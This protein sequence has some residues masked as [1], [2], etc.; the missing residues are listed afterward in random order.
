MPSFPLSIIVLAAGKGKRMRTGLP[1]VLHV[2]AGA[3]LLERVV[4]TAEA[5]QPNNIYVVAGNGA[6]RVQKEMSHLNVEWVQQKEQLGTGHAVQQVLPH[7]QKNHQVLILYGDVPL[8]SIQT[9]QALLEKTPKNA[10]GLVV[11]ELDDPKGFGRIIR[12]DVGNIVAIVEQKDATDEQLKIK[13]INTGII[14]VSAEHLYEWLPK[15]ENNNQQKEYYLTDIIAMAVR[16]GCSV[17]G[18]FADCQEEVR[19]VNNLSELSMLE[20]FYHRQKAYELMAQGVTI[21]DPNR[22]DMRGKLH[23]APD[24]I[25]DINVIFEGE[26]SI[27]ANTT[28]GPNCVLK[29]VKIGQNVKIEANSVI[30]GAIIEDQAVI[31]P[32]A[33]IRPGTHVEKKAKVGNFVEL[34]N[35]RLG[36][37]SKIPHLS[38][39][40]D[41]IVGKHVNIGAGTITVNYDGVNKHQ[42]I[43][44][45]TAFIGCD[46]QLIAP[47][48]VGEGAYIAAG[49]TITQDAPPRQLTIA[50]AK[51]CSIPDWKPKQKT[52]SLLLKS[53]EH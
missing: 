22:F 33:R 7:L 16:D 3:T 4:H 50:R 53:D 47:V 36:E 28:I 17:G 9:L 21:M 14:T 23:V 20:R 52:D 10:L 13:E 31:G 18:V 26:V 45:D 24:V 37:Q 46:S 41:A 35:V 15:L 34:K 44:E 5:L 1:K 25:V 6:E 43:I 8:I 27:G 32:F 19:G 39:I 2:L 49:S 40:G 51:Q 11:A 38:Y 30:E 12:N 48:T 42:T 29:N